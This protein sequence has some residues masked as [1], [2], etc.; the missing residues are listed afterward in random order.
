LRGAVTDRAALREV[1]GFARSGDIVAPIARWR[2]FLFRKCAF[3]FLKIKLRAILHDRLLYSD[4]ACPSPRRNLTPKVPSPPAGELAR[5]PAPTPAT[6]GRRLWIR[7]R[8]D[9]GLWV[10]H[11][12]RADG[13]WA[14]RGFGRSRPLRSIGP[15]A[16]PDC[17]SPGSATQWARACDD[18]E[19]RLK[20]LDRPSK[21]ALRRG[22]VFAK[23]RLPYPAE[24]P[25][26]SVAGKF[27]SVQPIDKK[28]NREIIARLPGG[29]GNLG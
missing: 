12:A 6:V 8:P 14:L 27:S 24:T 21:M 13:L 15:P 5:C 28:R 19:G 9:I 1:L 17:R 20:A 4:P 7:G 26:D 23:R 10:A 22:H 16:S 2:N 25:P 18:R 3:L 11:T 29:A